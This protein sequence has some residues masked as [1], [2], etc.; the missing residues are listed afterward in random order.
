MPRRT[1]ILLAGIVLAWVFLLAGP[2]CGGPAACAGEL[3]KNVAD[4]IRRHAILPP[5]EADLQRL[6][7]SRAGEKGIRNFLHSFDRYASL[8]SEAELGEVQNLTMAFPGSV[9]MDI[10]YDRQKNIVCVPAPG[11]PA[12]RAGV[13]YGDLLVR[14]DDHRVADYPQPEAEPALTMEDVAALIRGKPGSPVRLGLIRPEGVPG[15]LPA[16]QDAPGA[17]QVAFT[18]SI[19]RSTEEFSSVA[20]LEPVAG[21]PHVH[22]FRFGSATASEL[23]AILKKISPDASLVLDLRGNTGGE[24]QSATE[25]LRRFQSAGG[26]LYQHE[27]GSGRE[28]LRANLGGS[29]S[30]TFLYIW[31]DNLT[32]SAAEMLVAAL[33]GTTRAISI[34]TRS[35]GKATMQEWFTLRGGYRLKLST[36]RLLLPGEPTGWQDRGLA[37][38]SPL[39]RNETFATA[40]ENLRAGGKP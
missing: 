6:S 16:R 25:C 35:A 38:D 21:M 9:G 18:L 13:R 7:Q 37:P 29:H 32:A 17:E 36:E 8:V 4:V 2:V 19:V 14:V 27:T 22:I 11:S 15:K 5:P 30:R 12:E 24:V 39:R 33:R 34:G 10:L 26:V 20:L 31:Q 28:T 23:G 1:G 3:E 40:T